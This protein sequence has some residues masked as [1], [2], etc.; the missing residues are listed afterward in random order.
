[1]ASM[2]AA[3]DSG[4]WRALRATRGAES[5]RISPF[6]RLARTHAFAVA[7]DTL[8]ALALADSLFFSIDPS[9]ARLKVFGYLA[10]TVAP[11]AVVAPLIGPVVDRTKGGRRWMV[12][13]S[14]AFRALICFLMIDD[15]DG[16]LLFPEAFALLVFAKSYSVSK[17]ALVPTTVAG[18]DEL[19]TANSRL[20][21]I[22]GV[23]GFTAAV[24]GAILLTVGGS[25]WVL[26]L[27]AIVFLVGAAFAAQLPAAKV[28]D[29]DPSDKERAELRSGLILLS[30]TA[31]G[32]L[33]GIVGFL[34]F[35][36]AFDLRG[37][38]A[39]AW[40]FGLVLAVSAVG[41]LAGSAMAPRLRRAT[42]EENILTALLGL[43]AIAGV[44][45]AYI[46]GLTGAALLAASV[47]IAASAG[48]QAFD[49]I[50]QRDAPDA[51]R[52]RSFARFETRFQLFWVAGA[53]IPV[54][55]PLLPGVDE[56]PAP[57]GFLG[58]A[59]TAGFAV[60]SYKAGSAKLEQNARDRDRGEPT[61]DDPFGDLDV[62]EYDETAEA[63]PPTS[64][65]V[66]EPSDLDPTFDDGL[67]STE[68]RATPAPP[69][70]DFT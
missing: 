43:T 68:T 27:A 21:L 37:G 4:G 2:T 13:G 20:S 14:Q 18:D 54:V 17:S 44:V 62:P 12:L 39:P 41:S 34:T 38:D 31:M 59:V 3:P 66:A 57:V 48:K 15:I 53:I 52:G 11:F 23:M 61:L 49:S 10:L 22:S 58:V 36:L 46:G 6:T 29:A 7:G 32:L 9:D 33:R 42:S 67:E 60:V 47:G 50:V 65:S 70:D 45:S 64:V 35:L 69:P 19:V 28:A 25:K 5:F 24:P 40:N 30:A 16:L 55:V 26:G 56:F 63:P 1:M 8:V 51:N